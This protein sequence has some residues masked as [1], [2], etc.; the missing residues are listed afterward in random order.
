[1]IVLKIRHKIVSI[2][3]PK[4]YAEKK[5]LV[6]QSSVPRPAT[7]QAKAQF[8]NKKLTVC[9]IGFGFGKNAINLLKELNIKK[10][11]CVDIFEKYQ[12]RGKTINKYNAKIRA[13]RIATLQKKKNVTII[14][15]DSSKFLRNTPVSFDLIYI[16]GNHQVDFIMSDLMAGWRKLKE[17]GILAGHDYNRI[18]QKDVIVAVQIFAHIKG[19]IPQIR[20]PDFWFVKKC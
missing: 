10:L 16:D 13:E 8:K 9:E 11:Y 2:I 6:D 19:V 14:K 18:Y 4:L 12:E 1:M 15:S 3:A 20:I 17:N 5:H 7:I